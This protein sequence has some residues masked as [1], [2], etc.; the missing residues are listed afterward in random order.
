V[1][2]LTLRSFTTPEIFQFEK[3]IQKPIQLRVCNV[4]KN[5][6]L[7]CFGDFNDKLLLQVNDFLENTLN[8]DGH[9]S[10]AKK[11][12]DTIAKQVSCHRMSLTQ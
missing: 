8:T 2:L 4:L 3:T 1:F 6:L 7:S 5:W 10:L 12:A 11:L 9:A